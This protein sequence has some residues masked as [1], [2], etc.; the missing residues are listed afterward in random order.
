MSSAGK[1]LRISFNSGFFA[2]PISSPNGRAKPK[3]STKPNRAKRISVFIVASTV[4]LLQEKQ[5]LVL[6]YVW[7]NIP[8]C[9]LWDKFPTKLGYYQARLFFLFFIFIVILTS[10]HTHID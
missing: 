6:L 8:G 2:S 5:K 4:L 9:A 7:R 3:A 1:Q 10:L